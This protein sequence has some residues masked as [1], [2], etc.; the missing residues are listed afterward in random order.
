MSHKHSA[1]LIV[2][3]G[4]LLTATPS[5]ANSSDI[6][7]AGDIMMVAIPALAYGSTYY[8]DDP[9]GRMQF[10][11][12][13]AA[14]AV[15][16]YG[17]KK[18]VDRERPDHSDNDSFPS[19]HTSIAFQGASFIHKRY[20]FE[21]S[22]PAYIGATFVGYSRLEADKHHTTDVLAGAALGVASSMFLT[23]SYYDDTLHVSANLAPESY[24]LAVHYSF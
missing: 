1:A 9:E 17:L 10:Y 18:T 12:S 4:S 21:Y 7:T 6:E 11:K 8:M 14:N 23:K 3:S 5:Y 22:I 13:F 24:Q 20:G 19:A 16:T 15:T 2:L